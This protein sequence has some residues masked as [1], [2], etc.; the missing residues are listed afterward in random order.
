MAIS[1]SAPAGPVYL[2]LPKEVL[3]QKIGEFTFNDS[4]RQVSSSTAEPPAEAVEQAAR[5]ILDAENPL[6]ITAELG[7]YRRGVEML[8]Q[9]ATRFAIPV[10]E[11]GK[12]NFFNFPTNHPMHLGFSPSPYV[13]SADLLIAIESHVPYV[14]ALSGVNEPPSMLQIGVDP[15]CGNIPMRSFPVDCSLAGDPARSLELLSDALSKLVDQDSYRSK[16]FD[17]V[18]REHR[19]VFE[20]AME[21]AQKDASKQK[22]TKRYLSYC[23]GQSLDDE[24]VI[25]NEYNLDPGLVPRALTDSW[26]ENSIA[27]GLGWSFG[28]ALGAQL[29]SP[30]RTMVVTLGDGAYLFNTPLS[31]HYVAG[32]Y[33]LPIVIIVFNDS[34]WSTIKK[35]YL[36]TTPDG[37]AARKNDFPL[38]N[39]DMQIAFEQVAEACGGVGMRVE[40]PAELLDSVKTALRRA[41]TERKHVLLNVICQRDA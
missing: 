30:E 32:A 25:F 38:C 18:S 40:R 29:A 6:I 41:R 34:A 24:C 33:K 23:I 13:E 26:F 39:L 11:H 37:W 17:D 14:P 5:A 8:T 12:R 1:E 4:P 2:T 35:S 21:E 7:R 9:L 3:C 31:A 36:G 20:G 22:I 10:I 19:R 27:S 16:R 15:L 28:A